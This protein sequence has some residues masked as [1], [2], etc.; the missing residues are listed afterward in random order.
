M[1]AAMCNTNNDTIPL[2]QFTQS[3]VAQQSTTSMPVCLEINSNNTAAQ[4]G[5]YMYPEKA[6]ETHFTRTLIFHQTTVVRTKQTRTGT[7]RSKFILPCGQ[8][9]KIV[10]PCFELDATMILGCLMYGFSLLDF[11]Y[12]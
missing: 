6:P 10:V 9:T 3:P 8:R 11:W 5:H 2:T 12:I 1:S 4:I 7:S